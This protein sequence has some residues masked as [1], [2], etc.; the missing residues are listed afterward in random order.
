MQKPRKMTPSPEKVAAYKALEINEEAEAKFE[1]LLAEKRTRGPSHSRKIAKAA[2]VAGASTQNES[3]TSLPEEFKRVEQLPL[4]Q[5]PRK[6][7]ASRALE[8]CKASPNEWFKLKEYEGEKAFGNARVTAERLRK[9]TGLDAHARN[10]AVYARYVEV[11]A[12]GNSAP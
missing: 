12:S 8:T 2:I 11:P 4:S 5:R 7:L 6:S 1:K 10:G 3:V 9:G